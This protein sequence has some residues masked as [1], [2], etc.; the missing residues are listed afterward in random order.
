MHLGPHSARFSP[1]TTAPSWGIPPP[2]SVSHTVVRGRHGHRVR[3]QHRHT[4]QNLYSQRLYN[5]NASDS[6]PS[7]R[8]IQREQT[9][10]SL[11]T[12]ISKTSRSRPKNRGRKDN[13]VHAWSSNYC[14]RLLV[15]CMYKSSTPA[16]FCPYY[17]SRQLC[18]PGWKL[19]VG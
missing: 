2:W 15:L 13:A 9:Y 17:R 16:P 10:S 1:A 11:F 14:S 5:N 7:E 6:A 18:P 12:S 8:D 3:R 19:P 4:C